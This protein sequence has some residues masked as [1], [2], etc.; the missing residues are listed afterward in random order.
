MEVVATAIWHLEFAVGSQI[1]EEPTARE[2][3]AVA[4]TPDSLLPTDGGE[5]GGRGVVCP[6]R[7]PLGRHLWLSFSANP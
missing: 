7:C 2:A 1:W 6:Q 3:F 4:T 5:A